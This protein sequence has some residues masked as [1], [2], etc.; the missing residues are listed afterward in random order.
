MVCLCLFGVLL[1]LFGGMCCVWWCV[2]LCGGLFSCLV[3]CCFCLVGCVV[4]GVFVGE[5]CW[6]V[7]FVLFDLSF[8]IG[9]MFR[10]AVSLF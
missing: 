2:F 3:V 7:F 9:G 10:L 4:C 5:C 6:P 1:F 8:L